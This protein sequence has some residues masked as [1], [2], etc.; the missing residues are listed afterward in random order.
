MHCLNFLAEKDALLRMET[1]LQREV[2]LTF[3]QH[4]FEAGPLI[5][6]FFSVSAQAVLTVVGWICKC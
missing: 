5:C 1:G 6:R 2:Q 3:E 4:R